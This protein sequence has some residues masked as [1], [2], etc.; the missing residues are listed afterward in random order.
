MKQYFESF[1]CGVLFLIT[2]SNLYQWVIGEA[3]Y[4]KQ[5]QDQWNDPVHSIGVSV[6]S[7]LLVIG[8]IIFRAHQHGWRWE[9]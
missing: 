4:I 9:K 3:V 1:M 5:V 8:A 2:A 7:I 6:L